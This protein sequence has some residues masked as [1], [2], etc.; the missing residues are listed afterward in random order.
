MWANNVICIRVQCSMKN[1]NIEA[2][3]TITPC[4]LYFIIMISADSMG[5]VHKTYNFVCLYHTT[6]ALYF[7][8]MD[9]T[10]KS[11]LWK[12][13]DAQNFCFLETYQSQH[14]N[15]GI[16]ATSEAR[17]LT[18]EMQHKWI[19]W[20]VSFQYWWVSP[21]LYAGWV[22]IA[23]TQELPSILQSPKVHHRV[24]KSPPLVPILSQTDPVQT[25]PSYLSKI[26]FNIAH[27]PASWSS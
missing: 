27:P 16:H 25:I 9:V 7:I 4:N 15:Y 22:L 8:I 2:R 18:G 26:Y 10:V 5:T 13:C 14:W 24:H 11:I 1:S 6:K 20:D 12:Q 19:Q 3:F 23:A 17:Y 21:N